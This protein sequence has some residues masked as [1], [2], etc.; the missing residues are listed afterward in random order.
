MTD[1]NGK[2]AF[3]TGGASGA[4]L[5]QA[6]V[7][8]EAGC[9]VVIAD[10]RKDHLESAAEYFK[11]TDAQV[12]FIELDVMDRVGYA[13]AADETEK[14]FGSPPDILIMTA[15]VNAYGPVEAS[16]YEDYDWVVGVNFGG[17]VNGLVTFVPRMIK[18]GKGG[19][20]AAT[21]S[22][23]A[24][25]SA[26][27]VAPY[28]AA[29]AAV[30]SLLE[31]YSMSLKPYGIGVTALCPANIKSNIYDSPIKTRP[32]KFSNTGYYANEETQ[33]YLSVAHKLGMEPRVLAQWLKEGMENEQF[34]VLPYPSAERMLELELQRFIDFTTLEGIKRYEK[35]MNQP[36]TEELKR[37]AVEK[38]GFDLRDASALP[39]RKDVGFGKAKAQVDWVEPNKRINNL[40]EQ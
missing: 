39:K 21:V 12:H 11:T 32:E 6:Q 31:S 1:F 24:F 19:H 4:G 37:L 13:N 28:C 29:K 14:V 20:I 26:P 8:S 34:L 2:I 38:D 35:R 23:G 16:T 25:I 15:G 3:I 9:K 7:F 17:V 36:Q 33:Q 30:L 27:V 5:G 10:V 40:E 22:Y 18:A